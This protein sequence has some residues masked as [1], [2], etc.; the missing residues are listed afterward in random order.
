MEKSGSNVRFNINTGGYSHLI[1]MDDDGLEHV[2]LELFPGS[3]TDEHQDYPLSGAT[4]CSFAN[5]FLV[6]NIRNNSTFEDS[7]N[8]RKSDD[9]E[10][11]PHLK[12]R[13]AKLALSMPKYNDLYTDNY[14]SVKYTVDYLVDLQ[15][16]DDKADVTALTTDPDDPN[17]VYVTME[18]DS[19]LYS[20][21]ISSAH[22]TGKKNGDEVREDIYARLEG[23]K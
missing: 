2:D 12:H 19:G 10:M 1:L 14:G 3:T 20:V 13:S 8:G 15:G 23:E 5:D 6:T 7:R 21:D 9:E 22:F 17:K 16:V 11:N 4:D 18:G